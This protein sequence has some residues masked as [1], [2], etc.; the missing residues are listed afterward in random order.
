LMGDSSD[1]IPGVPGIGEKTALKLISEYGT[2]AELYEALDTAKLSDGTKKKL[3]EG[4]DMAELSLALSRICVNA[5][6]DCLADTYAYN[7]YDAAALRRLFL[8]LDFTALIK[9][10]GLE[11][12]PDDDGSGQTVGTELHY[13]EVKSPQELKKI[14]CVVSL[15][16]SRLSL[17]DGRSLCSLDLKEEQAMTEACMLLRDHAVIC[18]DF[19]SIFKFFYEKGIE[20][21]VCRFDC[22]LA[23]YVLDSGR[24]SYSMEDLCVRYL[25]CSKTEGI[26]DAVWIWQ[27]H[28]ILRAEI[29]SMGFEK[30]LNEIDLPLASVLGKMEL[31]GFRIDTTGI[32]TY[33]EELSQAAEYLKMRIYSYAGEEFNIGSPKQL[34]E[35][36]FEKMGLPK[37]RKTKTGYST[38]AETLQKLI[39]KHPIIEDILDYRQVTKLKSTYADGLVKAADAEGRIHSI[40]NQTGTATGRLS[41]SEPNLQNIPVRTELGRKFRQF[42][43]P[44]NDDYV[45]I[46]ADYSQI[47]LR[48][49]A[50]VAGDEAMIASFHSGEDI[51]T[52]TAARVFGVPVDQVTSDLR[53]KAK[54]VNF[55]IM[56]GIGEY[57]LSEDL[58]ITRAQAKAYIESYFEQFPQIRQYLD[59]VQEE[60][61]RDGYVTTVF[62][63]R[64]YIPEL[65]SSNRNVQHFGERVAMN[66]PIQGTAADIIKIAMIRVDEELR[67][68][69]FDAQMILQVHDELLIEC[70]KDCADQVRE[71]LVSC[72]ERAVDFSVPM[73]VE[74]QIGCTWYDAK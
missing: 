54:A 70:H 50:H 60:A 43:I 18:Y 40:L 1:N 42:F 66:S 64:R 63:R 30:L 36:L 45:L 73:N 47:E 8:E 11:Q 31:C 55:G 27:M 12:I 6:I 67:T 24:S 26:P 17:F 10:F 23:A 46:D 22:M 51:H 9:K 15:Q 29:E 48:L 37:S 13:Q 14:N 20:L 69:G 25:N 28:E 62:G 72:M 65:A 41:S 56:Y 44:K 61:K 74:A 38:D 49:L 34:G 32:Q 52:T 35:I 3:A 5:P 2:V 53:K 4:K 39:S 57:S 16:G 68:K 21:P 58:S 19:K 71:V 59:R 7:G 33:G